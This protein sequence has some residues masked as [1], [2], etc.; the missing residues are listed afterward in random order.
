MIDS[1]CGLHCTG[2]SWK[3]SHGCGGCITTQG[4]PF[5]GECPIAMCCQAK[6][7]THCGEC[8]IIPCDKLYAYSY[9]DP[10][11]GDKPQGARVATCRKWAADSGR[12]AW[13]KVLLTSAGF[14]HM[15]G[16]QK[17][18]VVSRFLEIL[19][20]PADTAKVLFIPTAAISDEA[21]EMAVKCK[22]ELIR[23]GILPENMSIHDIDGSLNLE[24]AMKHDVIYFTGG[25]TE[26]LMEKIKAAKF[27]SIIKKMVYSNKVYVG[28]SAGSLI[29]APNIGC[30][31][32]IKTAG[33]ALVHAYLSVH[34]PEGTP[35]NVDSPLPHIP[36]TDSQAL[37]VSW[38]GYGIIED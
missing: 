13:G 29:A 21:K 27:D 34:Q 23:I 2:C 38:S 37:A 9:L 8:D 31:T 24:N 4:H 1:R 12:Q 5:H 26:Y 30:P 14:E 6:G 32:D 7:Y 18:N 20:K 19:D 17:T 33:L 15:D 10:D 16:S 25:D 36:L 11:H 35:P 22:E 3:E 28:V